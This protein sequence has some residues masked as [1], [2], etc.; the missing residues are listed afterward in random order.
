VAR[1]SDEP[2][3]AVQRIGQTRL[4]RYRLEIADPSGTEDADVGLAVAVPIAGDRLIAL[5]AQLHPQVRL[6][7]SAV[8]VEVEE[9]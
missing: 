9:P 6:I 7:P 5:L 8:A 4:D 3:S 1:S 2:P